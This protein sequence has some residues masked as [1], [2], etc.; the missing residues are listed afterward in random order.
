MT[1]TL[2]RPDGLIITST[3]LPSG[4]T[5][6]SG[7]T[8]A[9]FRVD[10]PAAGNWICTATSSSATTGN[11]THEVSTDSTLG[12]SVTMLGGTYPEPIAILASV[13]APESVI[14][15]TV[16]AEITPPAGAAAIANIALRDDGIRPDRIENDGVYT[17]ALAH[18]AA[19][20]DYNVKVVVSNPSATA[21][22][23]TAGALEDGADAAPVMLPSF[24][25]AVTAT[26]TASNV[27]TL[28]ADASSAQ[29]V[30][31]DNTTTWGAIAQ[32]DDE[33]WYRFNA[34][35]G[36]AY[37][38]QT[39]KLI[40]WDA[41]TMATTLVLYET[42]A[43]TVLASS[44]HY[45]GTDVSYIEW[46]APA[47]GTY[48]IKVAH[49]SPGTGSYGLTVGET[50]LYTTAFTTTSTSAPA[51]ASGGGGGGGMSW[52]PGFVLGILLMGR[53]SLQGIA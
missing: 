34:V 44:S 16:I 9:I 28:P 14:G 39:S 51:P 41:T 17:G 29:L 6:T 12:V 1:L 27:S 13:T 15:A 33:V 40:S 32:D 46:Q 36:D 42:D 37:F 19:N 26:V 50:S 25:R 8:Y 53:R 11:V 24:K 49:A 5:Y 43:T 52:L 7:D 20:G 35:A 23:D 21:R 3:S 18:Y 2:E 47:D 4:V 22:L 48:Y 31:A 38:I 10:S 30:T 45:N